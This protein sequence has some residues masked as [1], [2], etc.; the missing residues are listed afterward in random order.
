MENPNLNPPSDLNMHEILERRFWPGC[1]TVPEFLDQI[2]EHHADIADKFYTCVGIELMNDDSRLA[3][4][5]MLRVIG[6]LGTVA[7]PVHDSFLIGNDYEAICAGSWMRSHGG[8][9]ADRSPIKQDQTEFDAVFARD[10]ETTAPLDPGRLCT[11][12]IAAQF[13]ADRV[14]EEARYSRYHAVVEAWIAGHTAAEREV[15]IAGAM[16]KLPSLAACG[17]RRRRTH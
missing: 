17:Y 1:P 10:L 2:E 16:R 11:D 13:H 3:E 14:Q 8:S 15:L 12:E 9:L 7:L 4:S 6:E 5:V